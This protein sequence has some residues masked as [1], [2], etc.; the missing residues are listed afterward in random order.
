MRC[1]LKGKRFLA[2]G[3][4]GQDNS[5]RRRAATSGWTQPTG[6]NDRAELHSL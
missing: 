1:G 4:G 3:N 6:L 2:G 5:E